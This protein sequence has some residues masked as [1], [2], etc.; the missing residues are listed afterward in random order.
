[1]AGHT[2]QAVDLNGCSAPPTQKG[3]GEV[4][5]IEDL[6]KRSDLAAKL[7]RTVENQKLILDT[8]YL[9]SQELW[10]DA[11]IHGRCRVLEREVAK[12]VVKTVRQWVDLSDGKPISEVVRPREAEEARDETISW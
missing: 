2:V 7:R 3:Q 8:L 5:S 11:E 4:S 12:E 10:N 9:A 1:M 6:Q